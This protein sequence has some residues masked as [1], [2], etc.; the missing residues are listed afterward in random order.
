LFLFSFFFFL[1][2]MDSTADAAQL[3]TA[4]ALDA[5]QRMPELA[6]VNLPDTRCR[7]PV[8]WTADKHM[9]FLKAVRRHGRKWTLVA[10]ELDHVF[11]VKDL[12][13]HSQTFHRAAAAAGAASLK[14]PN[15][16][17]NLRPS[18]RATQ[19]IVP[20]ITGSLPGITSLP[21]SFGQGIDKIV[22]MVDLVTV[23]QDD[24]D[25]N[26]NNNNNNNNSV[27][28]FAHAKHILVPWVDRDSNVSRCLDRFTS[29]QEKLKIQV[30]GT[31]NYKLGQVRGNTRAARLQALA[32]FPPFTP[33]VML[34][35]ARAAQIPK[36]T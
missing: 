8:A 19:T 7:R 17:V 13:R 33:Q 2:H 23:K 6:S 16:R 28:V 4:I 34:S 15:N 36:D 18:V 31:H 14:T 11:S 30:V 26:N 10:A 9:Q 25:Y 32:S 12:R 35:A 27:A 24:D 21:W 5:N 20:A 29:P 22:H 3:L 1:Q